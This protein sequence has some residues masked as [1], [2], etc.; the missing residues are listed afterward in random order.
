MRR[1]SHAAGGVALFLFLSG[2][3]S[4]AEHVILGKKLTVNDAA[5]SED[6]RVVVGLGKSRPSPFT[7]LGNP[8]TNG[9]TL[10]AI[11]NGGTSTGQVFTLDGSGWS[12]IRNGF[13]YDGPTTGDPV[14]RVILKQVPV[15]RLAML[16]VVLRGGVGTTDLEIVPPNPGDD[17]GF[18]LAIPGGDSYCVSFGGAAGGLELRDT[19]E[20]WRIVDATATPGCPTSP[21]ITTTSTSTSTSVTVATACALSAPACNGSCPPG[22]VCEDLGSGCFCVSGGSNDCTVCD[23]PCGGGQVCHE[24]ISLSAGTAICGCTTP[25]VCPDTVVPPLCTMGNCPAGSTCFAHPAFCGCVF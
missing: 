25:P 5:G 10:I 12:V 2:V 9:A 15:Y 8:I 22:S 13:R 18:I 20:Q 3:A 1:R 4:A 6:R 23:P 11:A 24:A 19:A 21:S 14:R 7:G 17:G 16:K